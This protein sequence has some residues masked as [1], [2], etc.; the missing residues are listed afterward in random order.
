MHLAYSLITALCVQEE[1]ELKTG[2]EAEEV[3]E[4]SF[5]QHSTPKCLHFSSYLILNAGYYINM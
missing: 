3:E 1:Q 4:G 5:A 2:T